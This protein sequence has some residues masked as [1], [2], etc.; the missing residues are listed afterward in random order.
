MS[1]LLWILK[2]VLGGIISYA[3]P[4]LLVAMGVPLDRW[5][6]TMGAW[7]SIRLTSEAA[8]W[9]ATLIIVIPL[10]IG[11]FWFSK[12]SDR[13]W[14]TALSDVPSEISK[15][16]E[17]VSLEFTQLGKPKTVI[18]KTGMPYQARHGKATIL[19][20]EELSPNFMM[21]LDN[22]T[23][24]TRQESH[25]SE[26]KYSEK[27]Y[28]YKKFKPPRD[29]YPPWAGVA[30]FWELE[31][32]YWE[33]TI[34]WLRWHANIQPETM[35]FQKFENGLIVGPA[36]RFAD[37]KQKSRSGQMFIIF[38]DKWKSKKSNLLEPLYTK[39]EP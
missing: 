30:V 27:N 24:L 9:A 16:F 32:A 7:L 14:P 6:V 2:Y 26:P 15:E 28:R 4:R 1:L 12:N 21:L 10:F 11:T 37:E 34:G 17:S 29:E 19:W 39:L 22:D 31:P 38:N 8:L 3:A 23:V 35:Y 36:L 13:G 5:I 33:K 18:Q 25:Y 20:V